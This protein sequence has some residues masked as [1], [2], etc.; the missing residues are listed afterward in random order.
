MI[1]FFLF[2]ALLGPRSSRAADNP[3][4]Q[5]AQSYLSN[6]VEKNFL[7]DLRE[8][9]VEYIGNFPVKDFLANCMKKVHFG[10]HK[11]GFAS[12]SGGTRFGGVH[13]VKGHH[14]IVNDLTVKQGPGNVIP[15]LALHEAV[16]TCY[17]DE[18]YHLSMLIDWFVIERRLNKINSPVVPRLFC[19]LPAVPLTKDRIYVADG[20]GSSLVGGGGSECELFVKESLLQAFKD[21]PQYLKYV[22]NSEISCDYKRMFDGIDIAGEKLT[23]YEQSWSQGHVKI[24]TNPLLGLNAVTTGL[25]WLPDFFAESFRRFVD[26]RNKKP[27]PKL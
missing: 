4:E 20:G 21:S 18:N 6:L 5:S 19:D 8:S 24:V 17:D 13:T 3:P 12:G 10:L 11:G 25:P 26:Q 27:Q 2:L 9:G 23:P 1:F 14:A 22:L 7:A 16:G 15:L